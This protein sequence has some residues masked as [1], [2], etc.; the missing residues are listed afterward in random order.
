MN[1]LQQQEELGYTAKSPSVG[2]LPTNLKA[3]QVLTVL[4]EITYQVGRTG[5]I[6]PVANLEPVQLAGT[7][8]KRASLHNAD[9]I[10]K[11]DIKN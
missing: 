2:L 1:N 4:K 8:V 9:Q 11:L 5:A 3:A 10:N 7:T 6:T